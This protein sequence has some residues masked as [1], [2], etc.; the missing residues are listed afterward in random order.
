MYYMFKIYLSNASVPIECEYD[1]GER[2][3][4]KWINYLHGNKDVVF[5]FKDDSG[6]CFAIKPETIIAI[7][8]E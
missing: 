8:K 5:T 2:L 3:M 4:K 7:R 6:I 1:E